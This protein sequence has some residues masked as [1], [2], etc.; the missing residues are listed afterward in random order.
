MVLLQQA[1]EVDHREK[2]SDVFM[3]RNRS[4]EGEKTKRKHPGAKKWGISKRLENRLV[5]LVV[6]E[7]TGV[8]SSGREMYTRVRMD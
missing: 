7:R 6:Q 1:K 5:P 3:R 2:F 4:K 8:L